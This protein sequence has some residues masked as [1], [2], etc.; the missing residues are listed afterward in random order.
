[1]LGKAHPLRG[2]SVHVRRGDSLLPVTAQFA[3]SEVVGQ[4][5]NDVELPGGEPLARAKPLYWFYSPSRPVAVL[6]D[7]D[8][9]LTAEAGHPV[10]CQ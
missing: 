5:E 10:P 9:C 2:E 1:M 8:W 6:R 4:Y 3:P 7:G